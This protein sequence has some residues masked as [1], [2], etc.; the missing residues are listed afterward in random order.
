MIKMST[1]HR[2]QVYIEEE[3][4]HQLKIEAEREYLSIS[5]LIRRA[6]QY[7]LDLKTK[8]VD[9]E[10]DPLAKAIG[11]VKLTVND[12]SVKH[13]HYLYGQRKKR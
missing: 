2:T 8:G 4:M 11:K 9:W 3:Q 1:L 13:N 10:K 12:A 6:V 5:E 7:Q